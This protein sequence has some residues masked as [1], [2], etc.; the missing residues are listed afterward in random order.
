M[1]DKKYNQVNS[2]EQLNQYIRLANP[3]VWVLLLAIVLLLIG[4]CIW[5]FYGKIDTK[6]K[7]V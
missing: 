6:I 3:G 5:G 7:T 4:V 2:P 1:E